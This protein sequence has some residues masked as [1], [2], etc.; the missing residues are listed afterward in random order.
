MNMAKDPFHQLDVIRKASQKG[1]VITD[2]YRLMYRRELWIKAYFR[3]F[4]EMKQP[5]QEGNLTRR[6]EGI[7]TLLRTGNYRFKNLC[8]TH[9]KKIK[10]DYTNDYLVQEVICIILDKVFAPRGRAYGYSKHHSEHKVL[11]HIQHS[12]KGLTWCVHGNVGNVR[13]HL[14]QTSLINYISKRIRDQRFVNLIQQALIAVTRQ[15]SRDIYGKRQQTS[16]PLLLE[17]IY[18]DRFDYLME[19]QWKYVIKEFDQPGDGFTPQLQYIRYQN[20][21]LIGVRAS[22][23]CVRMIKQGVI[24][25]LEHEFYLEWKKVDITHMTRPIPFLDYEF[26]KVKQKYFHQ[27]KGNDLP[28]QESTKSYVIQLYIS[29]KMVNQMAFQYGYGDI[30]SF[31]ATP[32]KKL[33]HY[34]EAK[35]LHIY[36]TELIRITNYYKLAMNGHYLRPLYYLAKASFIKTIAMKRKTSYRKEVKRMSR[37]KQGGLGLI[38]SHTKD[39]KNISSL[40]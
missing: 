6:L 8:N 12:W 39:Q 36:N 25:L 20:S 15:D 27:T 24:N 14:N 1:R 22:K 40:F 29:K 26:C 17:D 32:R 5:S 37:R 9:T 31:Q 34:T 23:K 33:L 16:L 4:P 35:I 3:L 13:C 11:T 18:L 7:I 30:T 21:F 38:T 28:I 10:K 2:C 19:K